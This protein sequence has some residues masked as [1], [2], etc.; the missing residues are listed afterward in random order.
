MAIHIFKHD[1]QGYLDW[2]GKNPTG[3]VVNT[4]QELD[5]SYLILHR[6]HCSTMKTHR[7]QELDPGGFTERGYQKIC[8][9]NLGELEDYLF[10]VARTRSAFTKVCS[11]CDD[12]QK[13]VLH[14]SP[15]Q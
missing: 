5:P 14:Q 10:G 3:Y 13:I 2:I 7:N 15:S 9:L 12:K 11:I 1:E 4:R 8:S 6:A